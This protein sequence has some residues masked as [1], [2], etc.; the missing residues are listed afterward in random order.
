MMSTVDAL[1]S[2]VDATLLW[3]LGV[4]RGQK[5]KHSC[6]HASI[7]RSG[8][9]LPDDKPRWQ[10]QPTRGAM[11]HLKIV[12]DSPAWAA[13]CLLRDLVVCSFAPAHDVTAAVAMLHSSPHPE[14]TCLLTKRDVD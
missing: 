5:S 11:P 4:V 14:W 9:S 3:A 10:A 13:G 2:C 1:C 6:R 7:S 12:V 8:N